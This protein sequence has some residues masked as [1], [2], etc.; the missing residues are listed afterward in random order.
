V[1][2]LITLAC[3]LGRSRFEELVRRQLD[4][5]EAD[6]APLLEEARE[7]DEAWTR[8]GRE[9]TE[10]LYG[11]YQLLVDELAEKLLDVRE[12]YASSLDD[13]TAD[14][15]RA[16]FNRAVLKR[17]RPYAALLLDE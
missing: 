5:F 15:Y 4:L 17:M 13:D 7:A 3:V 6:E 12:T 10:R 8:A 14:R 16:A 9:E 2:A 1:V 11:E